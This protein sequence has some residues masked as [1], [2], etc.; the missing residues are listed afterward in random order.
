MKK[1]TIVIPGILCY[2][3]SIGKDPTRAMTITIEK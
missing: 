3:K 2:N 1:K